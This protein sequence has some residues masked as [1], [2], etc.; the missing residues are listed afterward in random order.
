MCPS[1]AMVMMSS[2]TRS[3]GKSF[4]LVC[5]VHLFAR[6]NGSCIALHDNKCSQWRQCWAN[7]E[8]R[9]NSA[10]E[11]VGQH[12]VLFHSTDLQGA[13]RRGPRGAAAPPLGARR[14]HE[15]PMHELMPLSPAQAFILRLWC[16]RVS[17]GKQSFL[18]IICLRS[19]LLVLT[20]L[21]D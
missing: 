10:L 15:G 12:Y 6:N 5:C 19:T 20:D 16:A 8:D 18:L 17:V 1:V 14:R 13:G 11:R 9:A 2:M 21:L 4:T 3:L 7:H